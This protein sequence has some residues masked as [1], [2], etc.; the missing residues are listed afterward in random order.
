MTPRMTRLLKDYPATFLASAFWTLVWWGIAGIFDEAQALEEYVSG[1]PLLV[2]L[3]VG[4]FLGRLGGTQWERERI[5]RLFKDA[6][7]W[8][9]KRIWR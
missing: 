2:W 4:Y 7:P 9:T 5:N 8:Y 3:F 6:P 1:S